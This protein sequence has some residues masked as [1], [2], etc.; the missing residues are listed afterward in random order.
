MTVR[1]KNRMLAAAGD[2]ILVSA[3]LLLVFAIMA[4]LGAELLAILCFLPAAVASEYALHKFE[5]HSRASRSGR[6][7]AGAV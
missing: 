5:N 4:T 1:S 6:G 2:H 3:V 7:E